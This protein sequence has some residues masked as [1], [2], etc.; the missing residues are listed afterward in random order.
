MGLY[1]LRLA[2]RP[3]CVGRRG[4]KEERD[5]FITPHVMTYHIKS[6][7]VNILNRSSVLNS[8]NFFSY[9]SH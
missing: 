1:H 9:I 5:I 4:Q 7:L 2:N 6:T 3:Q 8:L